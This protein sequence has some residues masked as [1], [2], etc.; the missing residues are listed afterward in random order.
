M[1]VRSS[2]P[3]RT[4]T[5]GQ[6]LTFPARTFHTL[7]VTHR[8]HDG[9]HDRRRCGVRRRLLRGRDPGP[10]GAP[11]HPDAD[12]DAHAASGAAS[13]ADRLTV[14]MTRERTS[15]FP[16]RSDPETT[17]SRQ[18]T[19][20]TARTFTLV[21]QRQPVGADPRRRGRPAGRPDARRRRARSRTPTR[22]AG[23]PGDLQAT[24]SATVD[25]NP[26]TAWQPGLGTNAQV[27]LHADLRPHQ[28]ADAERARHAG[29]RRRP[30]LGPH[31]HDDH[32]GQPGAQRDVAAH[33][34]QHGARTR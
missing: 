33:R 11:G 27:G 14:V 17:I 5:S 15:Q 24:A 10:A 34:R 13:A 8:R 6:T 18:F 1:T 16:P 30:P 4:V 19:L 22:R 21:G 25:G 20:P 28:A 29:D 12:P 31:R 26:T 9:Q 7:R 2:T 3:R 32:L 23:C